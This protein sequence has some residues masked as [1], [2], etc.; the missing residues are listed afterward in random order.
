MP[1]TSAPILKIATGFR[2]RVRRTVYGL[3]DPKTGL[4]YLGIEDRRRE[5]TSDP[6]I[7]LKRCMLWLTPEVAAARLRTVSTELR[8]RPFLEVTRVEVEPSPSGWEVV[9]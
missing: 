8:T 6:I 4:W 1:T 9:K 5:F 3:T 2:P 7:A